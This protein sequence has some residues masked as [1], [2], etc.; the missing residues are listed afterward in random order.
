MS[1]SAPCTVM[2]EHVIGGMAKIRKPRHAIRSCR[3]RPARGG[4]QWRCGEVAGPCVGPCV[5]TN[6]GA[7]AVDRVSV[8]PG[9]LNGVCRRRVW[10]S[11]CVAEDEDGGFGA[12]GVVH[13]H[14]SREKKLGV[15]RRSRSR[16][17]S[18]QACSRRIWRP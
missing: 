15:C 8:L 18:R 9:A 10:S 11:A 6:G 12:Y 1:M 4:D 17:R 3:W 14:K 7:T 5:I 2:V 13:V 16:R